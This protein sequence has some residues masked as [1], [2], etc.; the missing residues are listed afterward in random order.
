MFKEIT[1]YLIVPKRNNNKGH[2]RVNILIG[3][4]KGLL[5][6]RYLLLRMD[7]SSSKERF[8]ISCKRF[9]QCLTT[10]IRLGCSQSLAIKKYWI[11]KDKVYWESDNLDTESIKALI[12]SK[13]EKTKRKIEF[14]KGSP[15]RGPSRQFISNDVKITVWKREK[16]CC[17]KC[18]SNKNLE[19]DH[20]IPV[21]MGGSSTERNLQLLCERCNREKGADL[22]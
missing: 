10:P 16:G 19:F 11:Y 4:K 6:N 20:I 2:R 12:D 3:P 17:V 22:K 14:A 15:R 18:G 8:T 13:D 5:M 7:S 9:N 21:A 1:D